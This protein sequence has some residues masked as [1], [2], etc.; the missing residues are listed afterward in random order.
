VTRELGANYPA[1]FIAIV[2]AALACK[3]AR[4]VNALTLVSARIRES[5]AS[6]DGKTATNLLN[7]SAFNLGCDS[8]AKGDDTD[9]FIQALM[10]LESLNFDT[11]RLLVCARRR[12]SARVALNCS[13][14][15]R[16]KH[17]N[18]DHAMERRWKG[19]ATRRP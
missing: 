16:N 7:R 6:A 17:I 5:R 15:R 1:N 18:D 9:Y 14:S 12:V 4:L 10:I 2:T 11:R 19:A 13:P 8:G 3:I